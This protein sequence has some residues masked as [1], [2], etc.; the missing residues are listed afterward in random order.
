MSNMDPEEVN[1]VV[2]HHGVTVEKSYEPDDFPVPAIAFVVRSTRDKPV[3]VRLIDDVPDDIPAEDI[4][5]HP[6]YG[7][8]HWSVEDS[9]IVFEREFEP[10]EEYTTVYGLR[11]SD[12]AD[13]ERFLDEP[14]LD[15]VTPELEESSDTV[16]EVIGE[17]ELDEETEE[18]KPDEPVEP[19]D[20]QE[21]GADTAGADAGSA[22]GTEAS[23]GDLEAAVS[24]AESEIDIDTDT[25]IDSDTDTETAPGDAEPAIV[26]VEEDAAGAVPTAAGGDVAA[27]LAAQIR[28][29]QVAERDLQ[30]L[31]EA[32]DVE[33]AGSTEARLS[34][35]QQD[36]SDLRAYTDALE[37]FLDEN[38][39]ARTLLR[40]LRDEIDR[41][42]RRMQATDERT[43]EAVQRADSV[44]EELDDLAADVREVDDTVSTVEDRLDTDLDEVETGLADVEA[45]VEELQER[46]ETDVNRELTELR[47]EVTSARDDVAVTEDRVDDVEDR[48]EKVSNLEDRM[49]DLE[50]DLEG[51]QTVEQRMEEVEGRLKDAQDDIEQL[52]QMREQLSSVFGASSDDGGE[53]GDEE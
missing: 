8:E 14:D 41:L 44:D 11:A 10:G 15:H 7:A 45:S 34:R 21:P 29:G 4:G 35:L 40:E 18:E 6:Q 39:E 16:G 2:E 53:E 22:G 49:A 27:A 20:L 23:P 19:L 52:A 46:V 43:R 17:V 25:D 13:V 12:A 50:A 51:L 42:E 38:G 28:E 3:D 31:R 26:E 30:A 32:L 5:F 33:A 47:D 24:A 37:A 48:I 1:V 9:T 36:V